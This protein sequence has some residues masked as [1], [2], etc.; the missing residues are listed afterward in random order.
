MPCLTVSGLAHGKKIA[1]EIFAF[2]RVT[3]Q[4]RKSAYSA[5]MHGQVVP[6]IR[7]AMGSP[8]LKAL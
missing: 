5:N 6:S 4:R 8:E 7:S 3:A 1:D 2:S